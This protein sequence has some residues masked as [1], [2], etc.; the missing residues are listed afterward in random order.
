MVQTTQIGRKLARKRARKPAEPVSARGL[1]MTGA[2]ALAYWQALPGKSVYADSNRFP[3]DSPE[4]ARLLRNQAAPLPTPPP[5]GALA[6][7]MEEWLTE[8]A[9]MSEEE[10]AQAAKDTVEFKANINANRA[11]TGESPVYR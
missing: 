5:P 11:A 10:K 7:L 3:Q 2:E 6:A 8:D 9:A 1:P 4:L